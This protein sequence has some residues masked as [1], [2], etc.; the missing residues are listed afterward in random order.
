MVE[1]AL[2]VWFTAVPLAVVMRGDVEAG[3]PGPPS[4][5]RE[6]CEGDWRG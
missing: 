1:G 3:P 5:L 4:I 2:E 6:G